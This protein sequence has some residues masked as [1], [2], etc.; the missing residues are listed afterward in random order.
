M[1]SRPRTLAAVLLPRPGARA[2][3]DVE[4]VQAGDAEGDVRAVRDARRRQ[5]RVRAAADVQASRAEGY[6]ARVGAVEQLSVE[7]RHW[8]GRERR[9]AAVRRAGLDLDR[10]RGEGRQADRRTGADER[11]R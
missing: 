9:T 10:E 8:S 6:D 11:D 7:R 2:E 5:R 1:P 3:D 4:P